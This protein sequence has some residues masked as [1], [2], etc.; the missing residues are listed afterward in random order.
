MSG[1]APEA[2]GPRGDGQAGLQSRLCWPGVVYPCR[3]TGNQ[4]VVAVWLQVWTPYHSLVALTPSVVCPVGFIPTRMLPHAAL[5]VFLLSMC[6]PQVDNRRGREVK[7]PEAL[8]ASSA[9]AGHFP[10]VNLPQPHGHTMRG[11]HCLQRTF[12]KADPEQSSNRLEPKLVLVQSLYRLYYI[13]VSRLGAGQCTV[14]KDTGHTHIHVY[15]HTHTLFFSEH[16]LYSIIWERSQRDFYIKSNLGILL[17]R[18]Q[19][20]MHF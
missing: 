10:Y 20:H 16:K 15:T 5:S 6:L 17:N 19:M 11:C 4:V 13:R 3:A 18:T 14:Q 12:E 7:G 8:C 1:L 2:E 9:S